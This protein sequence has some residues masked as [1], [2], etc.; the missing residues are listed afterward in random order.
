[1]RMAADAVSGWRISLIRFKIG[2]LIIGADPYRLLEI[3]K[4]DY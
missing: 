2:F 4:L 1:M 3:P